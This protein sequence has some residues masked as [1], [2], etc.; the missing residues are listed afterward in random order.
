M[1]ENEKAFNFDY[2]FQNKLGDVGDMADKLETEVE[3]RLHKLTKGHTDITGASIILEHIDKEAQSPYIFRARI[4]L[5]TRPEY[6]VADQ[7][8][9]TALGALKSALSAVERQVREKRDKLRETWKQP[10]ADTTNN[11]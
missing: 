6:I 7:D 1:S 8:A 3:T 2:E 10:G 5:Y 9:D 4:V 11:P